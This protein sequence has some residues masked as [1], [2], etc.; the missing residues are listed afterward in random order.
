M[1]AYQAARDTGVLG[2]RATLMIAA[3]ALHALDSADSDDVGFGLDLGLRTVDRT[4]ARVESANALQAACKRREPGTA[5]PGRSI[6]AARL[7]PMVRPI[8]TT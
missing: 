8:S 3:D 6:N 2:V 5:A 1:A 7:T 4:A